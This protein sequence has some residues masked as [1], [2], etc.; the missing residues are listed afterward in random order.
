ML[1]R[2][3]LAYF[4]HGT[5]FRAHRKI[6]RLLE[7]NRLR[8]GPFPPSRRLSLL[9]TFPDS[10]TDIITLLGWTTPER[11]HI[12]RWVRH[13]NVLSLHPD[14]KP[15]DTGSNSFVMHSHIATYTTARLFLHRQ[16]VY[17]HSHIIVLGE[18]KSYRIRQP[19]PN[20]PLY[21]N[22]LLIQVKEP[23]WCSDIRTQLARSGTIVTALVSDASDK[24]DPAP[25]SSVFVPDTS[26]HTVQACVVISSTRF[27]PFFA[28]ASCI[29]SNHRNPKRG[30]RL[31][32]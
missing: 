8:E 32:W 29:C 31:R 21:N 15:L 12:L 22:P 6:T 11:W 10:S 17:Q 27:A 7:Q 30:P 14:C 16:Y 4:Q 20:D 23:A 28:T 24:K 25:C 19:L 1:K 2:L 26:N 3:P 18:N 5:G 9:L 13:N